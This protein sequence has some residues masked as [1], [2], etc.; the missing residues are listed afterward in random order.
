MT[1][2]RDFAHITQELLIN[3]RYA[4]L[5]HRTVR[6]QLDALLSDSQ[7]SLARD[8]LQFP[9]RD[10][11]HLAEITQDARG[12]PRAP[13]SVPRAL[14][15]RAPSSVPTPRSNLRQRS[16]ITDRRT[17]VVNSSPRSVLAPRLLG[18]RPR[19]AR[20]SVA[21]SPP[22]ASRVGRSQTEALWRSE[23]AARLFS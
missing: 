20:P 23:E 16:A 2:L 21:S 10:D 8:Q 1:Q 4:T 7:R 3:D 9:G 14:S 18:F 5:E 13:S 17:R 11:P 22:Y 6:E 19:S 15:S 12:V